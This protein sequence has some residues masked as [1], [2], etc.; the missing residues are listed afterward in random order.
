MVTIIGL[1]KNGRTVEL[2]TDDVKIAE[3][4]IKSLETFSYIENEDDIATSKDDDTLNIIN[5]GCIHVIV[6]KTSSMSGR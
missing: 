5:P 1:K 2:T 3:A 6:P 4:F